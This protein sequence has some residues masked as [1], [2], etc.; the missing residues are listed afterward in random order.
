[1]ELAQR[2]DYTVADV[3]ALSEDVRAEIIDG[4]I[5]LFASPKVVHQ[6]LTGGLA[7]ELRTFIKSRGGKCKVFEAPL[8]IYLNRDDKTRVEPDIFVV[9]DRGKIHENACYGAPDLIIQVISKSTKKRD[10]GLKM[11]KYRTAGVRE[12]WIIDPVR[13]NVTVYY[14]EDESQNCQYAFNEEISFHIFPELKVCIADILD[15]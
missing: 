15:I 3:D 10:Y 1:M 12:Y 5:F 7:Y 2:K 13:E 8:D 14:F 9:C 11:L 4:Q 6:E